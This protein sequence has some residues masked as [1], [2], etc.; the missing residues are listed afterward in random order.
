MTSYGDNLIIKN[1]KCDAM[2]TSRLTI[3][4]GG[5]LDMRNSSIVFTGRSEIEGD[6]AVLTPAN[7]LDL[8]HSSNIA[9][10]MTFGTIASNNATGEPGQI[11]VD[12]GYIYVC[13]GT[14]TWKRTSIATWS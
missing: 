2:T 1:L 8:S 13:V 11:Q 4:E 12:G 7:N 5:V 3:T 9:P 10:L 14:D 6:K